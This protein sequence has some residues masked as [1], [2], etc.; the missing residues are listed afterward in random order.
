MMSNSKATSVYGTPIIEQAFKQVYPILKNEPI[1]GKALEIKALEDWL[2]DGKV[3]KASPEIEKMIQHKIAENEALKMWRRAGEK[4][5]EKKKPIFKAPMLKVPI[6]K[7]PQLKPLATDDMINALGFIGK[8]FLQPVHTSKNEEWFTSKPE[9]MKPGLNYRVGLTG[10]VT[11]KIFSSD[12]AY[13]KTLHHMQDDVGSVLALDELLRNLKPNDY[14]LLVDGKSWGR[15][16][17]SEFHG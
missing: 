17:K 12:G 16:G 7:F 14:V 6:F 9:L 5:P 3:K 1:V 11:I 4:K 15:I 2:S 10:K 13:D 8:P